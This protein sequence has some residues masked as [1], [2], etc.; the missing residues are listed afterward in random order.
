M[1]GIVGYVGSREATP[2]LM[3]GLKR[4]E[5]R[6]YDSAGI[7]IL[8]EGKIKMVK[9]KGR[10]AALEEKLNSVNLEGS[11]GIGHTRWATHGEPSDANSHP[12]VSCGG[13]IAVVH[14][15]IIE[16]YMKLKDF[17]I[18]KGYNFQSETDTEVVANL[19]DYNYKGDLVK[20]VMNTLNDIE[21]AYALGVICTDCPDEFVAARKD[22]PLI[23]GLGE[24]E[25]YIA[26]DIPAILEYTRD[27]IILEDKEVVR[28]SAG[29]A[30][31][32]N[33]L[34]EKVE[35][36]SFHVDWDVA[37]AEKGGY[38][39]FMMKEI[40]E[41]PAVVKATISPR[42]RDGQIL[43]ENFNLTDEM[44]KSCEK[45]N[46]IACGTAYHAGMV[47]KYAIERLARIPVEADLASEFRYRDPMINRN[48]ITIIISQSGETLDTLMA[49]REARKKGSHVVSIVNVVGSSIARESDDV[50][51]TW[52]GPEIAVAS[53]KA[54][55]TQLAVLYLL[56]LKFAQIR[57]T[58]DDT[59][60]RY[61]LDHLMNLPVQMEEV[62]REKEEIQRFA[63][64]HYNA[65]SIFFIGRNL[66]YALSMEGSLKLKEISYI[67]S[68]AY[69][70]GELKH[71][72]IAL[73]ENGTLVICPLTQDM[74][75]EKMV[76]NIREVKARGAVV[77]AITSKKHA[78]EAEK[79]ADVVIPIPDIDPLIAPIIAVTPLQL[80]AYYVSVMKGN[81]VDKPRNLAKSVTVE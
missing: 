78:P 12:H 27:V 16:N 37:S 13:K 5:Y 32:Y 76:S 23:V 80:F 8:H 4:L 57:G 79:V 74:L 20:A 50:L 11:L 55:N 18:S 48:Q 24:G 15:G 36:E 40:C 42:I 34:G 56:A 49:L 65:R 10:L 53:T 59:T 41:E 51:Y 43:F 33:L 72:T 66:D 2:V 17:L 70:G 19:I 6:G 25:N 54:Y 39:H 67:H 7:A 35:R 31:I 64:G 9:T 38:E 58:V 63:A 47:G 21:G 68:E 28:I 3:N 26:S 52:A 45:I 46:I 69:A 61:Y 62:L 30:E 73:I 77:M 29:R 71:G 75:F 14:N 81:D 22:S 1:C 44:V 60:I